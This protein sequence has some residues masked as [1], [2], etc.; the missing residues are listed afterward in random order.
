MPTS[1]PPRPGSPLIGRRAFLSGVVATALAAGCG[2][3]GGGGGDDAT[4]PAGGATGAPP[5]TA[6]SLPPVPP[7]LPGEVFAL[8][9]ASGDPQPDS[10]VLWTRLVSDPLAADGGVPDQP[11]PVRW[12]VAADESF[13]DV[14]ASGDTVAEPVLGHSVHIDASGLEPGA[15]YWY[16]FAIGDRTSPVGRTRTAPAPGD[17]DERL[18]FAVA[19]CQS[20]QDGYWPAHEHL[21]REDVDLVLFLGDY[22]YEDP[23]DRGA[24]R[25]YE[26][27]A[28]TDLAGYRRRYGE[29]KRDPALLAAHAAGPWVCTWDDHEVVT[30]YA[31]LAAAGQGRDEFAERRAAAYQAWYE[32]MPV[33]TGPPGADGGLTLHRT[34]RWGDLVRFHV[35]D[36]RQ[37]RSRQVCGRT[38]DVG[39][40]CDDVADERRSMLGDDQEAWLADALGGSDAVWDVV[41]Q[42]TVVTR[43]VLPVGDTEVLNLDQW[44][45]YPAARRRLVDAMREVDNPVVLSG[46]LHAGCVAVVTDDPDDPSS[47]ARVPEV[48]SP[49]ISSPFPASVA[50]LAGAAAGALPN[51]RYVEAARRG[52][53]VCEVTARALTASFRYVDGVGEPEAGIATLAR[54]R[55]TAGDPD[56]RPV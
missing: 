47:R 45:G 56:P 29:Y 19:S 6:A 51:V 55:V 36:G 18:R 21:A 15:G 27:P 16:R 22:I 5:E 39:R 30:N 52:Y 35:L 38:R 49:S 7:S 32:H 17:G 42:Q 31:G 2:R 20:F 4:A 23:P 50:G 46:D 26:T 34:L 10:V 33:R 41:A 12:E 53:A 13:A 28:P 54:W 24:V 44:D 11:L 9:V 48:V 25:T 1:E 37:H 43:L 3:D 40:S 8:G 14:V